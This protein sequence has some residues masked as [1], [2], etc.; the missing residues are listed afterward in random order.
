AWNN[1]GLALFAQGQMAEALVAFNQATTYA[2]QEVDAWYNMAIVLVKLG[3]QED[4]AACQ[5][6][7]RSLEAKQATS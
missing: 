5:H 2:P 1:K 7:A 6:W 4:A 3:R